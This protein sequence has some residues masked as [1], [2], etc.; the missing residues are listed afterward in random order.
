MIRVFP[1]RNKWT[2]TDDKVYVGDPPMWFS[3]IE[4][5]RISVTFTFDILEGQRLFRAY[6]R[7]TDDIQMGGPAFGDPG[8]EFV[9]GRFLRPGVTITSRGCPRRCAFCFVPQREGKIRELGIKDGWIIQDNNLLACSRPH[10]EAVFEMLRK[11]PHPAKFPGGIDA[12]LIKPWHI[13]LLKSIRLHS[14]FTACDDQKA[15]IP[16]ARMSALMTDI[17]MNKK[18]CY[19]LIGFQ[20]DTLEQAEMR[21]REVF[22]LGFLPFAMLY[23]ADNKSKD[24]QIFQRT[25]CRPAAYKQVMNTTSTAPSLPLPPQNT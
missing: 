19:V 9:P 17:P 14:F 13:D 25:W 15:L 7:Y 2:P 6:S 21:L 22:K 24:W 11:Q 8:G 12:R 4:P 5:I 16:L 20:N 1:R 10:I 3:S 23:D 18:R